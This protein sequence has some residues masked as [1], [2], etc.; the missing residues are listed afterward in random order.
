MPDLT[1]PSAFGKVAIA[2]NDVISKV[3]LVF[4]FSS[5]R[6]IFSLVRVCCDFNYFI[7]IS[8][9]HMYLH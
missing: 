9:L 1:V 6:Y 3:N 2:I 7:T 5:G 4:P 8:T